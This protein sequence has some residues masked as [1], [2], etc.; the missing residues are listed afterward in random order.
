MVQFAILEH[1]LVGVIQGL[2]GLQQSREG[3]RVARV[4]TSELAFRG[5]LSLSAS[6]IR[7]LRGDE[8]AKEYNAVLRTV[9]AAEEERNVLSHS[10]WAIMGAPDAE[11]PFFRT[12]YTA[13][14]LRGLL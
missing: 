6:L 7:E 12:K 1:A 10:L 14:L 13:K 2:L 9:T 8:L 4:L 11:K 3:E 5:L